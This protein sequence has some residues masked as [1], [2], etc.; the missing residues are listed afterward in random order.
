MYCS[1]LSNEMMRRIKHGV[2]SRKITTNIVMQ[3]LSTDG[4]FDKRATNDKIER[5]QFYD[6]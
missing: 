2:R 3:F 1:S 6:K 4:D 5:E